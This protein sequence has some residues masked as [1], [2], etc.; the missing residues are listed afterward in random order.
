MVFFEY[1]QVEKKYKEKDT[2]NLILNKNFE[3]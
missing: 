3:L 2:S 1:R